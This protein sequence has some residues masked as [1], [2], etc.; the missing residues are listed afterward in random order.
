MQMN[1]LEYIL[2]V[3]KAGSI[4]NAA[5]NLHVSPATI[6]Q[7]ISNLE[8]KYGIKIFNRSRHGTEPTELGKK[9][10]EEAY[11][12]K[13]QLVALEREIELQTTLESKELKIVSH[14]SPLQSFLPSALANF[15]K[16]H[17][18]IDIVLKEHLDITEPINLEE[19]DI[20]LVA[21]S[22]QT[23]LKLINLYKNDLH[24][25]TI[26]QGKLYVCTSKNSSLAFKDSLSP[27]DLYHHPHAIYTIIKAVYTDIINEYGSLKI[28]LESNNSEIIMK[29][30]CNGLAITI[31]S[32]LVIKNEPA[33]LSG[34]TVAIPLVDYERANLT[35]G[36]IR[37][38]K[39]YYSTG[40]R[41]FLKL[42]RSTVQTGNY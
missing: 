33:I 16:T 37:S 39:R 27:D 41:D 1:Q 32:D 38:K 8:K 4:S 29:M 2:E 12:I 21:A 11:K 13:D 7:S 42:L 14:P 28:L 19:F 10:L 35:Y 30:V 36:F 20:G 24:F 6:S 9:I 34:D 23:W 22:P 3:R 40:A 17:P 5:Q 25:E 15:K 31:L 26:L 18:N